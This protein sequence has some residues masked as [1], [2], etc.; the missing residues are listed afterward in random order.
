MPASWVSGLIA[1]FQS[2]V[3]IF[4]RVAPILFMMPPFNSR[5][6]PAIAKVGL[7]L[8]TGLILLPVI[9]IPSRL[10]PADPFS[11]GFFLAVE[12]MIGLILSYSIKLILA[13]IQMGGDFVSLQMG[14]SMANVL[15]PQS[16]ADL[17]VISQFTYTLGLLVFL[18]IDGHHWFFRALIQ[19]F[20]LLGPGEILLRPSLCQHVVNLTGN[21]LIL[22]FK[23]AAPVTAVLILTQI[24]LG[25]LA[26]AVPQVNILAV[27]PPLTV[28]LGLLVLGVS[29]GLF[30]SSLQAVF[31]EGTAGLGAKLL[32]LMKR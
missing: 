13:G 14:L 20:E 27:S 22:A 15:D 1:Q 31:E 24:A 12:L 23:M 4:M 21:M 6:V 3:M 25:V 5:N 18:S 11:F 29:L 26:K 9:K 28:L 16:G 7:S 2:F 10:L 17:T 32:P 8:M 30:W 19:S